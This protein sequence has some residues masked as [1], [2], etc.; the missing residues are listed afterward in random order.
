MTKSETI[1]LIREAAKSWISVDKFKFF[2]K[3]ETLHLYFR[4]I[5]ILE[6]ELFAVYVKDTFPDLKVKCEVKD[7]NDSIWN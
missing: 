6:A 4:N 1:K 7:T 2:W 3:N 5:H